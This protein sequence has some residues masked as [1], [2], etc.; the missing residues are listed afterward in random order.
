MSFRKLYAFLGRD[1]RIYSKHGLPIG[2]RRKAASDTATRFAKLRFRNRCFQ[3]RFPFH[4]VFCHSRDISL[5]IRRHCAIVPA[6]SGVGCPAAV[7]FVNRV[8]AT[9]GAKSPWRNGDGKTQVDWRSHPVNRA[10]PARLRGRTN[11]PSRDRS[12]ELGRIE[13]CSPSSTEACRSNPDA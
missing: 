12:V 2:I 3:Q 13:R 9:L 11:H 8:I 5:A 1:Q 6:P 4:S 7:D 10:L